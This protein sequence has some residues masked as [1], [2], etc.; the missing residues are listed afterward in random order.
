MRFEPYLV[1]IVIQL[2]RSLIITKNGQ[3]QKIAEI[4]VK[5]QSFQK[6]VS[7]FGNKACNLLRN[8]AEW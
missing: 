3:Q 6:E 8:L 5:L 4:C 1:G 7:N 2:L